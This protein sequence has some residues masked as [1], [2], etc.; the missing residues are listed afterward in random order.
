M[1][2]SLRLLDD[3]LRSAVGELRVLIDTDG[4]GLADVVRVVGVAG[5]VR[6]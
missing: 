1:D 3:R 2:R 5:V 6:N 4:D